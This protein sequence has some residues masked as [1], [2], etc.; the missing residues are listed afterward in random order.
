MF[1]YQEYFRTRLFKNCCGFILVAVFCF[2]FFLI[3]YTLL[4]CKN[5]K[6]K[7][8][9]ANFK[10]PLLDFLCPWFK[11]FAW[12]RLYLH[13][14]LWMSLW[15][16]LRNLQRLKLLLLWGHAGV[17]CSLELG[18][19][20]FAILYLCLLFNINVKD[21]FLHRFSFSSVLANEWR[22]M[23]HIWDHLLSATR[24]TFCMKFDTIATMVDTF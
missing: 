7:R 22:F 24:S 4:T 1:D 17:H 2:F 5:T 13:T 10:P 6:K 21:Q 23:G 18:R 14:L 3:I 19:T 15:S 9:G 8:G 11:Y 12:M 16:C 20:V